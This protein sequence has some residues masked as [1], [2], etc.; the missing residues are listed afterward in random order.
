MVKDTEPE[1][2]TWT[3]FSCR[4]E[5]EAATPGI[6]CEHCGELVC[7]DCRGSHELEHKPAVK[8]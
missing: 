6:K 3:C 2:E 4:S 1:E 8:G 5:F 7:S